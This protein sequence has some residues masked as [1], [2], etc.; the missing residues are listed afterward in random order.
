MFVSEKR[1]QLALDEA[2]NIQDRLVLAE[3]K[4]A[5]AEALNRSLD[6]QIGDFAAR[7]D[8]SEAER[9]RLLD[10]ALNG[11]EEPKPAAAQAKRPLPVQL[12]GGDVIARAEQHRNVTRKRA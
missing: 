8:R 11:A 7:L 1:Y 9:D 5:V 12:T 2:K 10:L 3:Q 6:R 4:L